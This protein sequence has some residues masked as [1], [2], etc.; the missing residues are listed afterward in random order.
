MQ[1]RKVRSRTPKVSKGSGKQ[2]IV[3]QVVRMTCSS[4]CICK[5]CFVI[6]NIFFYY[7][8]AVRKGWFQY[9]RRQGQRQTDSY[10]EGT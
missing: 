9:S 10:G 2:K 8:C 7:L 4:T 3:K 5:V 6:L 1:S